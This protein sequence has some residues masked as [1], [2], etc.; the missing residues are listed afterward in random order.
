MMSAK[1]R[2]LYVDDEPDLLKISKIYLERD[3]TFTIDALTSAGEALTRLNTEHYDAIISDYQMP[4]MDGIT[5]LKLLKASGNKTPFI[6]FTGRGREEV[7]IEALNSG[8]DFYLQKGGDPKS[9]FAEL[10]HK[11]K[12]AVER[13]RGR[14][15]S[16]QDESRLLALVTFYQMTSAPLKELMSFAI[17]KAGEITASSIGYLAFVSDDET[18]LTMYAWSAQ[19]MKEC[20]ID[21]KPIQYP[22]AS[23]GLWG[24]AVRQRRPVITNDYAAPSPLKKGHP[25]G[26]VPIIRHMNIPVFDGTHIVMVAGVGNKTSDYNERDVQELSLM[27]SGLWNVVKQRKS[28]EGLQQVNNRINMLNDI[29]RHNVINTL[30][31]LLGMIAMAQDPSSRPELDSLLQNMKKLTENV[32]E[33]IEF[34]RDFQS[35]GVKEPRWQSVGEMVRCATEPFSGSGVSIFNDITGFEV[36]ADPLLEKVFYNLIENAVRNGEHVTTIRFSKNL[37]DTGFS[38]IYEDNGAGIPADMK[39]NIFKPGIG[40]HTDIGLF[41][42]QEILSI[43]GITIKETGEPGKGARFEMTVPKGA[44]RMRKEDGV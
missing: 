43:T 34:T 35:I 42:V 31:G 20:N 5:F 7:A 16:K 4:D 44:W 6:I 22:L 33:Q 29:T 14:D 19:S 17:E 23:T 39:E 10:S 30:T 27:M 32:H 9:Q 13:K 2:V 26:H 37:S 28:E 21:K 36:Y 24:E 15:A 12:I 25:E 40:K 8:A 41:L 1:I 38:I 3:G 18:L 11:I